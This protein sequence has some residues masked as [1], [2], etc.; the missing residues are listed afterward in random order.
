MISQAVWR[1]F[2]T[3]AHLGHQRAGR[4]ERR[5]RRSAPRAPRARRRAPKITTA[6][7]GTWSS[8]ADEDRTLVAQLARRARWTICGARRRATEHFSSA[9]STIRSR[10]RCWRRNRGPGRGARPC[11]CLQDAEDLDLEGSAASQRMVVEQRMAPSGAGLTPRN[12]SPSG[13]TL[14]ARLVFGSLRCWRRRPR[15]AA[16]SSAGLRGPKLA[17]SGQVEARVCFG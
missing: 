8:F 3:D 14:V 17:C 16:R 9:R 5:P 1:I 10:G 7:S 11:G 2:A 4:V 13:E 12:V 15:A 6:P